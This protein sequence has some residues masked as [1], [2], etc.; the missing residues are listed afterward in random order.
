MLLQVHPPDLHQHSQHTHTILNFVCT[1]WHI[2]SFPFH[3]D[4]VFSLSPQKKCE[5]VKE[6]NKELGFILYVF[7]VI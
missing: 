1:E 6:D 7:P 5:W 3:R 2:P 4:M